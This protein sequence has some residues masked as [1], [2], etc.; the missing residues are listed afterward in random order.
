[1]KVIIETC[2]AHHVK[3]CFTSTINHNSNS[4]LVIMLKLAVSTHTRASTSSVNSL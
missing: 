3:K 1:M 2:R 4:Q